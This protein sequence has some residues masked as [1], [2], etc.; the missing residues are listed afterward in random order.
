MR[1]IYLYHIYGAK[2]VTDMK[3]SDSGVCPR[4]ALHEFSIRL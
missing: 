2:C 4:K 1:V 3:M